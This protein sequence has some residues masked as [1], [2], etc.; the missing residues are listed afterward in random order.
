MEGLRIRTWL[1]TAAV[2]ETSDGN[3]DMQGST[4]GEEYMMNYDDRCD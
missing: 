1:H 4:V 3:V 2:V